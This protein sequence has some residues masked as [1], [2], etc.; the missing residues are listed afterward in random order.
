[1][2]TNPYT[3]SEHEFDRHLSRDPQMPYRAVSKAAVASLALAVLSSVAL[4][5]PTLLVIP[6]IGLIVG[7]MGLINITRYP[8]EL[9]GRTVGWIGSIG[10]LVLF[11]SGASLH[12]YIYVT[13]V[14]DGYSR[15]SFNDLQ[16]DP[17]FPEMPIPPIALDMDGTKI[18]VKGYVY[19]DGQQNEIK[20]F[21]LVPDRGT[22]CF[23]GQ[24]KLTDMI[25]VTLKDPIRTEYSTRRRKLG[26]V[27]KVDTEKKPV[28]GLD[29][30][31]YQLEVDYLK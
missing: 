31:Y 8:G 15:I 9:T 22:C 3:A 30:V 5:F 29:G 6:L 23:G 14:P 20:R 26:G 27:L 13:E 17:D 1:M 18:F 4:F 12:A 7:S 16:P 10:C 25:E 11:M 24:P 2:S 28:S 19:P 21:V